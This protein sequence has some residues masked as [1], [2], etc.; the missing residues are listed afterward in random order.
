MK[1]IYIYAHSCT[2]EQSIAEYLCFRSYGYMELF[3]I[4]V[5]KK[6]QAQKLEQK[7]V[8][9]PNFRAELRLHFSS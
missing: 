7:F 6:T 4:T 2:T 9:L 8:L 3:H 5:Q 1:R